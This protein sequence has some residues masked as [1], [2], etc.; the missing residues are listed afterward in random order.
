MEVQV[1]FAALTPFIPRREVLDLRF[2]MQTGQ[3]NPPN[4]R[5]KPLQRIAQNVTKSM[6]L[7]NLSEKKDPKAKLIREIFVDQ[8]G[9]IKEVR[10]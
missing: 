4:E 2:S 9:L 10:P 6:D 5:L 8:I 7:R 3:K 1:G